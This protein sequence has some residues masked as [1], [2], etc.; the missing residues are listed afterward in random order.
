MQTL[1]ETLLFN[2]YRSRRASEKALLIEG[3][4]VCVRDRIG[5]LSILLCDAPQRL[6]F[7]RIA[8][9]KSAFCG[10]GLTRGSLRYLRNKVFLGFGIDRDLR[11]GNNLCRNA[12]VGVQG[13]NHLYGRYL[14][15]NA[16]FVFGE[17]CCEM[18]AVFDN[19]VVALYALLGRGEERYEKA[20]LGI[21]AVFLFYCGGGQR[22]RSAIEQGCRTVLVGREL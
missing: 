9:N 19:S 2:K 13:W 15:G 14:G 17:L 20:S 16:C 3:V 6:V 21:N 12:S 18:T 10:F 1:V 8:E 11:F 22:K 7:V 4:G 5:A